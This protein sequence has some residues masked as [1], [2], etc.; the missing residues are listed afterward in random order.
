M[1]IRAE[2]GADVDI[3]DELQPISQEK[4]CLING[5]PR[6]IQIAQYLI[7]EKLENMNPEQRDFKNPFGHHQHGSHN[8]TGKRG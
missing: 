1:Q 2:S 5:T 3:S 4:L 8:F 7:Q 6:Q